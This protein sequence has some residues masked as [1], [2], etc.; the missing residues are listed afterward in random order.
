MSADTVLSTVLSRSAIPGLLERVETLNRYDIH[1]K[2]LVT[3]SGGVHGQQDADKKG[4]REFNVL[5]WT[6]GDFK[7]GC[8]DTFFHSRV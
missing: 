6:T 2:L 5:R 3:S 7:G 4:T 8:I 1:R